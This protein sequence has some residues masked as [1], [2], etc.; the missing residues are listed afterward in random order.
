M[1]DYTMYNI[2]IVAKLVNLQLHHIRTYFS[3]LSLRSLKAVS[4]DLKAKSLKLR[5]KCA[6]F[7]KTTKGN[8][9]LTKKN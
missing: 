6:W 9:E 2:T 5:N 1:W 3:K 8:K 7:G 4:T